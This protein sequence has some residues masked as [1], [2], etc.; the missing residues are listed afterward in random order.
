MKLVIAILGPTAS[1]K[2]TLAIE[3]ARRVNGE[4]IT[5]DSTTVYRGFN[6]GSAKPTSEELNKIPHHLIDILE[7]NDPFSAGH[8]ISEASKTIDAIIER[9]KTPIIVGGTYFYLKALQHGMYPIPEIPPEVLEAVER[10]YFD[11]DKDNT[12]KMYEALKVLDPKSAETIHPN[13][14]YRLTRALAIIRAT[15]IAPSQLKPV[16]P[17]NAQNFYWLK[18]AITLPRNALSKAIQNRTE[19]MIVQG[20]V[21]ETK[22]LLSQFPKAK[23]LTSVG[24]AECVRLLQNKITENQLKNEII[25]KTRQLAKRQITWLRSDPEIRFVDFN[26]FDRIELEVTNL[27]FC[28]T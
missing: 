1:G 20:L 17:E 6:I 13:D 8:F 4:I 25:E 21:E 5:M 19:K 11:E 9:G 22:A 3:I 14:S 2:T 12:T 24:Y 7:P 16:P 26:D 18:Y 28:F 10:E 23:A 15:G 27:K